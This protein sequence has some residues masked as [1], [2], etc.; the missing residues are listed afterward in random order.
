MNETPTTTRDEI[1]GHIDN[2]RR[3]LA[4]HTPREDWTP[5]QWMAYNDRLHGLERWIAVAQR[6]EA[7]Q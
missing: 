6:K 4:D 2:I 5:G 3:W 7:Q 1:Q